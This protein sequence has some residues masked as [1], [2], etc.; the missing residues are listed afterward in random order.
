MCFLCVAGLL[1]RESSKALDVKNEQI[2][3][4]KKMTEHTTKSTQNEFEK[5]VSFL[6]QKCHSYSE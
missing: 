4:L 6:K 5:R 3:E 1:Q 2:E